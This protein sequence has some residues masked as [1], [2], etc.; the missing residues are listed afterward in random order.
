MERQPLR[1]EPIPRA[2]AASTA[3]LGITSAARGKTQNRKPSAALE[4][5]QYG[6]PAEVILSGLLDL[7][8][9]GLI[10][11]EGLELVEPGHETSAPKSRVAI[12]YC[13]QCRW[14][15]RA[16]WLAQE[17][18]STFEDNL[19][20]VALVPGSGVFVIR[21]DDVVVWY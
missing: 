8:Q 1:P 9:Q 10:E 15:A 3:R 16:S 7:G 11:A 4:G 13:T 18:L 21:V 20:H 12:E 2:L 19:G 14:L 6:P 17:L 5:G